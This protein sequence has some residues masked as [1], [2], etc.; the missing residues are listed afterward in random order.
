L[1][2]DESRKLLFVTA[3]APMTDREE[4]FVQEELTEMMRQGI[5]FRVVPMR[6]RL[7]DANPAAVHS[8][9]SRRTIAHSLLA[10]TVLAGAFLQLCS[11]PG[12]SLRALL[13]IVTQAGGSRNA[14]ANLLAF[15]KALWLAR[16]VR[17]EGVSHLHAY[18]LA[19]TT[20]A[21][22]VA[23]ELGNCTWSASGFRW[24]IDANNCLSAKL[25]RASFIRVAD[26]F[27]LTLL[28]ARAEQDG[29]DTP[30]LL[31]RTGVAVPTKEELHRRSLLREFCCPGAFVEKKA[32]RIVVDAFALIHPAFSDARLHFFGDGHLR[33][34]VE[35]QVRTLNLDGV[36][37][38]H[39]TV[40]LDELRAF[41]QL[42]PIT[43]LPS[44][45]TEG[46]E[47]EGIPVVLVEA[48][49]NGSPVVSTDTGAI[50]HL[51]ADGCGT[52]VE[53]GSAGAL[54]T[55]MRD[56]L[57]Q[58]P[59]V[60]EAQCLKAHQRVVSEFSLSETSAALARN[61]LRSA[62]SSGDR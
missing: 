43:L 18:W 32:Q 44:I 31:I 52:L 25:R 56:L 29:V 35:Q 1:P 12:T 9:L 61:C 60:T 37:E 55:A 47:Q 53:P 51:V 62:V 4:A 28:S 59:L 46:G 54:A 6:R 19:H 13:R 27:G 30:I 8:G 38:F 42:R 50:A 36:V 17:R 14:G 41:L 10:P 58:D 16:L 7:P 34:S 49:A 2:T 57:E 23:A 11:R 3:S 39:G 33:N 20:T 5:D 24:D 48:M 15:P 21:V 26:E 45:V 40:P 22:M